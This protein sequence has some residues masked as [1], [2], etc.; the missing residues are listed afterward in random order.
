MSRVSR[1][2]IIIDPDGAGPDPA[3]EMHLSCSDPFTGG[4]GQS[5]GPVEDVDVNWQIAFFSIV[6]CNDNG[7]IKNCGNVVNP[8]EVPNTATAIGTD[9]FGTETVS[10]DATVTVGPGITLDKLTTKG[11]R[12]RVRLTNLTGDDKPIADVMIEWPSSNG[13]LSKVWSMQDGTSWVIW[14]GMA[15]SPTTLLDATDGGWNGAALLTGEGIL[16]FDFANEV[17][18]GGSTIRVSFTDGTFLDISK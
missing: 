16:R 6:R 18:G 8:F 2:D 12:L 1:N 17:D 13:N 5:A 4:W 7:F 15:A 9:S 10:D 3:F 14:D 11:K